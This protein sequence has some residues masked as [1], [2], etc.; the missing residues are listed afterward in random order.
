MYIYIYIVYP[1]LRKKK[2]KTKNISHHR[3]SPQRTLWAPHPLSSA[4]AREGESAA[5]ASW[6]PDDRDVRDLDVRDPSGNINLVMQIQL[7]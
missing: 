4:M 2:K 6:C 1:H 7:S 5:A 3:P